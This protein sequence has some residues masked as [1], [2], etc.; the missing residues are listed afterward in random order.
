MIPLPPVHGMRSLRSGRRRFHGERQSLPGCKE[1][2]FPTLSGTAAAPVRRA[3]LG[4]YGAACYAGSHSLFHVL[5]IGFFQVGIHVFFDAQFRE[6]N[7]APKRHPGMLE[8]R[9]DAPQ[10]ATVYGYQQLV[11]SGSLSLVSWTPSADCQLLDVL[12]RVEDGRGGEAYQSYVIRVGDP[13]G[14]TPQNPNA[15]FENDIAQLNGKNLRHV[16]F[17][18]QFDLGPLAPPPNPIV[19]VFT[20]RLLC[21]C[22]SATT[23]AESTP[24]ESTLPLAGSERLYARASLVMLSSKMSTSFPCSTSLLARCSTSSETWI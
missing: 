20:G 11:A 3:W 6:N 10:G 23:V 14:N 12:L 13:P 17:R 2:S 21:F 16:R 4:D 18:I 9:P 7:V 8:N 1:C 5:D 19:N 22:I 24:P 15:A